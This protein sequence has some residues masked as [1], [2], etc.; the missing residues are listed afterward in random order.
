MRWLRAALPCGRWPGSVVPSQ[1]L[2]SLPETLPLRAGCHLIASCYTGSVVLSW[3]MYLG[4]WGGRISHPTE[5]KEQI[6][7]A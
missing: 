2:G 1:E 3:G 6:V 7:G 4:E 5:P